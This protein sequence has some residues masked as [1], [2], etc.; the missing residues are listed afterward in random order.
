M[1]GVTR[2]GTNLSL[3]GYSSL[4]SMEI[5]FASSWLIFLPSPCIQLPG[6]VFWTVPPFVTSFLFALDGLGARSSCLSPNKD[7]L[8]VA[9][10]SCLFQQSASLSHLS[11]MLASVDLT[12]KQPPEFNSMALHSHLDQLKAGRGCVMMGGVVGERE[13]WLPRVKEKKKKKKIILIPQ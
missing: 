2:L 6:T 7:P 1:P 4:S 5:K 3:P 12:R 9:P 8:F 11:I 10:S 13:T